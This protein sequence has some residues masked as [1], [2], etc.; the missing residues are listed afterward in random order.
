MYQGVVEIELTN[1]EQTHILDI[2]GRGSVIGINNIISQEEWI[3]NAKAVSVRTTVLL[4][5]RR[6]ELVKMMRMYPELEKDF[7]NWKENL[8]IKGCPQIDYVIHNDPLPPNYKSILKLNFEKYQLWQRGV[9]M[10][11]IMEHDIEYKVKEKV[12]LSE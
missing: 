12:K 4:R 9:S 5:L 1:G 8:Q 6:A 2:M 7:Q 11:E 3:F 10:Q